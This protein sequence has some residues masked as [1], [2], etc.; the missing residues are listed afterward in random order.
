[1]IVIIFTTKGRIQIEENL[2]KETASTQK[3]QYV[4]TISYKSFCMCVFLTLHEK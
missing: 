2:T 1:M 3:T 4:Q